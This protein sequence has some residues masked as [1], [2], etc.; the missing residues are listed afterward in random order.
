MNQLQK[1]TANNFVELR[2]GKKVNQL[3]FPVFYESIR[4]LIKLVYFES[5]FDKNLEKAVLDHMTNVVTKDILRDY[6]NL[7]LEE[8]S[9][10][11]RFGVRKKFGDYFGISIVSL[12]DW[13]KG[14][15]NLPERK[16]E[17]TKFNSGLAKSKE[18]SPEEIQAILDSI[19]P[20]MISEYKSKG[21]VSNFGNARYDYLVSTGNLKD[22]SY[23]EYLEESFSTSQVQIKRELH[24][25]KLRL[26]RFKV[27]ELISKLENFSPDSIDV[28]KQ[29]K[30]FSVNNWIKN[31][32]NGK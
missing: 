3:E 14:F 10:S 4:N 2:K 5:G 26:E 23:K 21:V 30:D 19:I 17:L 16:A 27:K 29:A 32:L 11:F 9:E 20:N 6:S 8:I 1:S 18:K 28:I 25:A 7:T 12:L 31:H 13:I 15:I 24:G 22:D